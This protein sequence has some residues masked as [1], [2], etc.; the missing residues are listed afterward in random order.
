MVV[1]KNLMSDPSICVEFVSTDGNIIFC[2]EVPESD[3]AH[4]QMFGNGG[5]QPCLVWELFNTAGHMVQNCRFF[6]WFKNNGELSILLYHMFPGNIKLATEDFF[7]AQGRFYEVVYTKPQN[8]LRKTED[9]M[10]VANDHAKTR[11]KFIPEDEAIDKY[12]SN[13]YEES[14]TLF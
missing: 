14:Q 1:Y 11:A 3:K 5:L 8:R 4:K 13:P 7:D 10:D 6:F 2:A 12:G 9:D